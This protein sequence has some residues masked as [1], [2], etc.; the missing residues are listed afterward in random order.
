MIPLSLGRHRNVQDSDVG[1]RPVHSRL[2]LQQPSWR[3][4]GGQREAG[5][6][7]LGTMG[8]ATMKQPSDSDLISVGTVF[9]GGC[10]EDSLEKMHSPDGS[11]L[12]TAPD[13]CMRGSIM[14]GGSSLVLHDR[15]IEQTADLVSREMTVLDNLC[16][17]RLD[18]TNP[19]DGPLGQ[20][21][22]IS[23]QYAAGPLEF[24]RPVS[25]HCQTAD[26]VPK[27]ISTL[28]PTSSRSLG[29]S[30]LISPQQSGAEPLGSVNLTS[31]TVQSCRL[32]PNPDRT[33]VK[34]YS[35][36]RQHDSISQV[37][38][39]GE[40]SP[41][42]QQFFRLLSKKIGSLL[43]TP[44]I[45]KRKRPANP[46]QELRRSRRVAGLGAEH[47]PQIPR[48]KKMVM[49]T[50]NNG[51]GRNQLNHKDLEAYAK[52]FSHPLSCPQVQALAALFGWTVPDDL[53][54]AA[55]MVC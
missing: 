46:S 23:P 12:G 32:H 5:D 36:R 21:A 25:P 22:L 27:E 26:L 29:L 11:V 8:K 6:S 1:W 9:N 24:D 49:N 52:L 53:G 37:E 55:T 51:P 31:P 54:G 30:G 17:G 43:A 19:D 7:P 33:A 41:S 40:E 39:P 3:E 20:V 42:K 16:G 15:D 4:E 50:I 18:E 28:P 45:M 38:P 47:I 48:A 2:A 44:K 10:E 35:R 13:P 14:Q 34:V